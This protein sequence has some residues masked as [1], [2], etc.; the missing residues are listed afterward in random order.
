[1][2]IYSTIWPTWLGRPK[3]PRVGEP[4]LR[5]ELFSGEQLARHAQ[6]LAAGHQTVRQQRSNPLLARL[7]GNEECLRAFHR[8]TLA[9]QS[10]RRI[11]PAAEWLLDNFYLIEEQINLAR[12]HLPR[13]YS[14]ELPQLS[15]GTSA[16]LPRVYDLVLEL[17]A[18][19]DAQIDAGPLR[20]FIAA[21]QTVVSL[22]L[23]ELW[24]IPIMLRLGLIE[25]LQRITSRL[26]VAREDRDLADWWVD[27]LQDMAEKNPSHLVIVVADM[28]KADLPV[29]SSFVAEFCQRLSRQ[30]PVLHLA[31]SWLEQRLVEHGLSL[32]H[33]VQLETQNQA[34]DQVSVSHSIASLR[35]LSAMDWKEFV[36]DLSLVN[37]ILATDP[38]GVYRS[39]DFATRDRYRHS[40]ESLARYSRLAEADIA[41]RAVALAAEGVGQNGADDRAA[42]VGFYLIDR[43]QTALARAVKV[44][45]PVRTLVE[46]SIRRHALVY[47]VGGIG[48]FT[49]LASVGF[50]GLAYLGGVQDWRLF[51]FT[52]FFLLCVSQPGVALIN[53]LTT[54]LVRP[55]LLPR[56][57][58]SGGIDPACRTMVVVPTMLTSLD[59]VDRL[60]ESLEIHHLANRDSQ[61]YFGL[62]TDYADAAT[63]IMP[64][65]RA[66]LQRATRGI[67]RLNRKYLSGGPGRF[68]LF[69]RPRRWNA[70]EGVWM[71]FERKRGKLTEFNALLRGGARDC[72]SAVVGDPTLLPSVKYVITLDTDTQLPREAARQLVG[73]MAHRLNRPEFSPVRGI[74]DEGYA[75]LQP[76]VGVSLP[77]AGRS[78]FVRLFA[79]EAGIDPYTRAV[80]DV[81][82][83]LFQEGSFIGKGIYDVDAFERAMA[84]R[85]PDNTI[86]SHDLL[87]SCHARSALVSDVELYEEYPS[88]YNVDSNRRHRWIRGDWQIMQWLLPRVPG[89][90]VRRIANPLSKLSQWKI[91]DNLRRSLI[92]AALLT[93]VVGDWLLLP[94]LAGAGELIVLVI[95]LLPGLLASAVQ[96]LRKPVDLPLALHLR[97]VAGAAGRQFGQIILTLAFLPY[98]AFMSLDAIGRTLLRLLITHRR[99]LEWRTSSEAEQTTRADLTGFYLTMW[100]APLAAL[101]GGIFLAWE[102]PAQ[103]ALAAP[104]LGLWLAA[105]W[106]AWWISRP[107]VTVAPDLTAGQLEFLRHTAR[108]TWYFFES[109]VTAREHWLPPDNFQEVPVATIAS[110][111]SPTNL[112]LA[113]L[114]N[115]S[116]RD[117]G[118]LPAGGL[119]R[120]TED[121]FATMQRLER[122]RGHFYN[123]YDTRTLQPLL[124]V[125]VSSVDSGNLAGHLLTLGA[126]LRELADEKI[127]SPQVWAGLRDTVG[128]LANLGREKAALA[129]LDARLVQA[130]SG[131]RA[132]FDLL[133][134]AS[135]QATAMAAA[136][137]GESEE[138]NG[139]AQTL[140]QNCADHLAE[141]RWL[142]PW[143]AVPAETFEAR[144]VQ[145][146]RAPT[147]RE[148]ADFEH[149]L[150]PLIEAARRKLVAESASA[151]ADEEK[152]LGRLLLAVREAAEHA[153]QRLILLEDL[154]R[155]SDEF[156]AMDFTF[157][158]DPA[159]DLFSTGYNVTERRCD[160]GFYDLLASEARLCSYVAIALGQVPQEHWFSLGRLLVAAQEE[161]IL[162][163]WSGSMFEY[164]MPLLVMPSYQHTLLDHTCQAAVRRQIDYARSRGVPW[165]ISESGYNLTDAQ[166]NYQYRA[167]GVPG[168]GLKRGLAEDLVIA[169]Y[170]AAMALMVTPVEACENLQRLER[171]GRSGPYGFYEAVDYTPSRLPPEE[172]S[173]TI[174]SYMAHHQGM[175][176]LAL[177]N[178]LRDC[179]MPRRFL[180]CPQL[181]AADLLLQERVPKAAASVIADDPSTETSRPVSGGGESVMRVLTNPTTPAPEV[182]L[183][184]NG[185][186]HVA[187]SSAGGGYSRWRDLAVTRW[188]ED[189]TRDCWGTFIY[190][191]DVATGEFWSAAHQPAL[192]ATKNYEAI[193][194]QARAEFRQNHSGLEIHTGI[195][196]SP[197]DD[198]ELR[199][200]TLTNRTASSRI[201]ELTSYAEVVLAPAAADT[202]HPAFSNLF[203]QT[204]F[205]GPGSALL[206][207][208][209][210]SSPEGRPPWL[211]HLMVGQ[212]GIQGAI[213]YETDRARFVGR[214]GTLAHPL[215]M[216][217]VAPL[218]NTVGS[219]L[220]PIIS[221]R[222]TV[223]LAP[224]E[225]A[226]ID[227]V[228]GVTE[229]REAA[230]LQVEKYQSPRMADR[231]VDLAWTHSQVTLH[232]LNATE[233]EAQLYGR[234]AG[235][236]I[237]A[238]PARR[239]SPGV[240]RN[241]RRGQNGLW[242]YGISGDAPLVLLRI[243]DTGK[244]EIVRQLIRAHS[245]WRMMD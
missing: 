67:E 123:W 228:L 21:Y 44:R 237:Y 95:I 202:A 227:L 164:L 105:P 10:G 84:G 180:A 186:Y 29:S 201:I 121:A 128:V 220:D 146:D 108:K 169:P 165:G 73:T 56:L 184:S 223:T 107:I 200:V 42:H 213:S 127:F 64:E 149:L 160:A 226:I 176:L 187:I 27:R 89:A 209:R 245:Y 222:R 156:A 236:L 110:R 35:F 116:A 90:D 147:L 69:H 115:L 179:P 218:S 140:K 113:L 26:A 83:D 181:K 30:S 217:S 214:G 75:I 114:A 51:F 79:G 177:V 129:R 6:A 43:G 55:E 167:F 241:N 94:R 231:A 206:C 112:G 45:W 25:N 212:G 8:A 122:H 132:A 157:L 124:P 139:W 81:Y 120:R 9:V 170:A 161:P 233:G 136:L 138:I 33:L 98:D 80:S 174:R 38:A 59:G 17:I 240:L 205:T 194:T 134:D 141:L 36:E 48:G 102:R 210:A 65:D 49:L 54:L 173:V 103:L 5:A 7:D 22:K 198:V 16:G 87:E 85:F 66:L 234:M 163:S 238:D 61:L 111:T 71:G 183:L 34:A 242:S 118:Y 137:A 172:T 197:E 196:V 182:H 74:V 229:S 40:V 72:F 15:H 211:L 178:L 57:D 82:Q 192:R 219:V 148:A 47:Y 19:A 243:S 166:L 58:Y 63:A 175:S 41:R 93:L 23:G 92:P 199:R 60:I 53:W 126:G 232:Q 100:V 221:L 188:R 39:M 28:A 70:G 235:A 224:H 109:F 193:F 155:Q 76:R 4:P 189:A 46:R 144:F 135:A 88:R 12:R 62:L 99:L 244:I 142:A 131:L 230:L 119:I 37:A 31:R 1:M 91:F 130:P 52:F 104:L 86:L 239:A 77:S 153:G 190:L 168:L 11:T 215:A 195:S 204:E 3:L 2:Q 20:A 208:R 68:F 216:Q 106:I 18:H 154:A 191:R 145:L 203:V 159:R 50:M 32:E 143:L 125:Y 207:T 133:A 150:C 225:T 158:F 171:D 14:R 96:G 101:A 162:I 13:G 151:S 185:R 117:F 24:A 78:W 97:G 152:Y